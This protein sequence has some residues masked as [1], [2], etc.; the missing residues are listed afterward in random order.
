MREIQSRSKSCGPAFRQG[1]QKICRK[2]A[3]RKERG[4]AGLKGINDGVKDRILVLTHHHDHGPVL[5]R[6][7]AG[8]LGDLILVRQIHLEILLLLVDK[9]LKALFHCVLAVLCGLDDGQCRRP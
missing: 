7:Q 8:V 4:S 1:P 2:L 6:L 3:R 5:Q 9:A